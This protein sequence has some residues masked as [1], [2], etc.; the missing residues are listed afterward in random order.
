MTTL[1]NKWYLESL[2]E[3]SEKS[4]LPGIQNYLGELKKNGIK[5][6]LAS[7]SKN[8][9]PILKKIGLFDTFQVI[10]DGTTTIKAKPDP[11]AF[12]T[13]ASGLYS[14][15]QNCLVIED[16]KAGV[17]AAKR[18]GMMVIGVGEEKELFEAD[19]VI[20]STAILS[21][22]FVSVRFE[23]DKYSA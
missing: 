19:F 2:S 11:E 23:L 22:Q 5:V 14:Q 8:A 13:C 7:A 20:R 4:I 18:A 9:K 1:K 21:S 12:L 17:Q 10:A 15:P 6:G 3:L 16:A